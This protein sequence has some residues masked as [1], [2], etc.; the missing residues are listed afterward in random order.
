MAPV[1]ARFPDLVGRVAVVTGA[2]R[3]IGAGTAAFL[4]SNGMSVALV[5]RS[6]DALDEV[7]EQI[8]D[9]GGR[10]IVVPTDVTDPDAL[11]A[12][13]A[14]I[15]AEL[16]PVAVLAAFA[17]GAGSPKPSLQMS[18]DDWRHTVN[19]DLTGTFATIRTFAPA[20]VERGRGSIVTM[21]SAAG[22]SPSRANVAYAAAKAG[23][24]M[25]TRHL[26]LELGSSGVRVN[27]IAPS[28]IHNEKMDA[29]M[30]PDQVREL[31]A[32]FPL[33]RIG[34]PIDVAAATAFFASDASG[35]ITG[36]TLDISGGKV[37]L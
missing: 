33:G 35:W 29:F 4:A 5:A 37:I 18:I 7:R 26:A 25:L 14:Q 24:G 1:I 2:S 21:S 10:A 12:A 27:C 28:A 6:K 31:G 15:Q 19:T 16:G 17:G 3:G 23:V 9:A 13:E 8:W 36:T 11:A 22:R 20:M 34:E 30:T 32:T